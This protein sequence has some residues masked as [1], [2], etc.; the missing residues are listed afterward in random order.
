MRFKMEKIKIIE[1]RK[2]RFK[3]ANSLLPSLLT[4]EDLI[5]IRGGAFPC[6]KVT[7]STYSVTACYAFLSCNEYQNG[8]LSC[9]TH[10]NKEWCGSFY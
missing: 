2:N 7:C 4:D 5:Q 8:D 3:S 10:T 6:G 9:T 1:D